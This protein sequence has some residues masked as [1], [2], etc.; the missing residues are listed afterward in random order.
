VV[1]FIFWVLLAHSTPADHPR[2]SS[3]ERN[4]IEGALDSENTRTKVCIIVETKR[5]VALGFLR[6]AQA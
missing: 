5:E 1:W 4:Y 2:I 3:D 6:V